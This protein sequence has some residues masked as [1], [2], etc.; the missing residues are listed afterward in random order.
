MWIVIAA[1]A[2]VMMMTSRRLAPARARKGVRR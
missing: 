2:T 1:A